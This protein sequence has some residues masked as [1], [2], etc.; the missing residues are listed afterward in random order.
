MEETQAEST[1]RQNANGVAIAWRTIYP[2]KQPSNYTLRQAEGR[3]Q[4]AIE[5]SVH[6]A[7]VHGAGT[8]LVASTLQ[9]LVEVK[10]ENHL[11]QFTAA[12]SSMG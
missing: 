1:A 11:G 12:I 6:H 7:G 3:P 10:T 8:E 2:K 9:L 5:S 4:V